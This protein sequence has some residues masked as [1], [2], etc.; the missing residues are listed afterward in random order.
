MN[1]GRPE[2]LHALFIEAIASHDLDSIMQLYDADIAGVKMQGEIVRGQEAMK[3]HITELL[4][5]IET[6][7]G[8]VTSVI[9]TGD[10]ALMST[11]WRG[12]FRM[13]DG[14]AIEATGISAEVARKQPNGYWKMVIDNPRFISP[15][16]VSA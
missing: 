8:E 1:A 10:L 16:I 4:Q 6:L 12:V 13:P 7:E 14:H 15:S 5:Q 3:R 2:E 9:S 11:S